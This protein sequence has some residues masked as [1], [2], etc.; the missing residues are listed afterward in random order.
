[1]I[2]FQTHKIISMVID[3]FVL[4]VHTKKACVMAWLGIC[5]KEIFLIY[6]LVK[7]AQFATRMQRPRMMRV[8]TKGEKEVLNAGRG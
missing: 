4:D 5:P 1:M 3:I 7:L 6:H 2:D 8:M